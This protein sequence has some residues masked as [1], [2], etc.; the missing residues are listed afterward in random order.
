M[1]PI[2]N[3]K[4][5]IEVSPIENSQ[6]SSYKLFRCF[7]RLLL[8]MM[9]LFF[10]KIKHILFKVGTISFIFL[11]QTNLYAYIYMYIIL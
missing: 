8:P 6:H 11:N 1:Y 2:F 4:A 7:V 9:C 3:M 5:R 10:M